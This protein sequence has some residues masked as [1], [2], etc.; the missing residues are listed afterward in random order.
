MP[1][2]TGHWSLVTLIPLL[3]ALGLAGCATTNSNPPQ[4]RPNTGYV[5]LHADPADELCWEV[6]RFEERSQSFKSVFSEVTSPPGGILRLAF[7]PGRHRLRVT[8]LNRFIAKPAEVEVEV[9]DGR[10]TPVHVTLT[11]AGTALV[12][13]KEVASHGG[14]A[15]GRY[16]RRVRISTDETSI[17]DLSAVADAPVTYQLKEHMPYAR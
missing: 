4:A 15:K 12:D 10:I 3:L 17:Y 11:A 13:T 14:T 6:A 7:A 1:L 5:D 16:G 2:L 8:F 9:Q